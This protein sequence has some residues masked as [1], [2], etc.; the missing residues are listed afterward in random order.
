M[1]RFSVALAA[2]LEPLYLGCG[3]KSPPLPVKTY[4]HLWMLIHHIIGNGRAAYE[5]VY[6]DPLSAATHMK[7]MTIYTGTY[8]LGIFR[9]EQM[10]FEAQ[11]ARLTRSLMGPYGDP[12]ALAPTQRKVLDLLGRLFGYFDVAELMLQHF[13]GPAFDHGYPERYPT[14][15]V[16][17]TGEVALKRRAPV[18]PT[19]PLKDHWREGK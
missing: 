16:T 10:T 1:G 15:D 17:H 7:D 13:K 5:A 14:F 12:P 11:K 2:R 19:D 3:L 18:E 8:Y 9:F 4:L 6:R